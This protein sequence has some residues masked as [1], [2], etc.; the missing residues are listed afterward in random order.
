MAAIKQSENLLLLMGQKKLWRSY[1]PHMVE[2][3]KKLKLFLMLSGKEKEQ[4]FLGKDI[5]M[6]RL[7]IT[8]NLQTLQSG[9]QNVRSY[10]E[11]LLRKLLKKTIRRRKRIRSSL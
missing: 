9:R 1:R 11:K 10:I 7:Q 2:M 6:V 3:Q 4:N 5:Q 8:Q